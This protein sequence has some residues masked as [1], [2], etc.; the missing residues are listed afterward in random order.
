MIAD[1]EAA[2]DHVKYHFLD[3]S[4]IPN[5]P[6]SEG[7]SSAHS[8]SSL[9]S[10]HNKRRPSSHHGGWGKVSRINQSYARTNTKC[11]QYNVL[12]FIL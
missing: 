11:L 10:S 6:Q 7:G 2:W 1:M 5:S 9:T 4:I 8:D 12:S 3:T